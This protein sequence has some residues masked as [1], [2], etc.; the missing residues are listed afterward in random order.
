MNI[1]P[2]NVV[3]RWFGD[4]FS[5]LHPLLQELH[6]HGGILHGVI[7]IKLGTGLAG[8]FGRRLARAVNI[9][10]DVPQC[11][12]KVEIRHTPT[13]LEWGRHFETGAVMLSRFQ[14]VGTHTQGH[15][16]EI[17]GSLE[18]L[19]TVDI[20]NQ[21]WHWRPLG[22]RFRGLRLPLWLL[23]KSSAGK[24]IKDG[25]YVFWVQFSLPILGTI[26]SYGGVLQAETAA[27]A[28]SKMG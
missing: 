11:G 22:A 15:W 18:M 25:S 12:F 5:E 13:T 8:W 24:Y 10:V 19:L 9:P 21:G 4:R 7:D 20:I 3:T 6:R 27:N 17:T 1:E 14:P 26:L 2:E 28:V 16:R 23:P